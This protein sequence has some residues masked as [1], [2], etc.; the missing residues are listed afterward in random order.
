MK[1]VNFLLALLIFSVS[2]APLTHHDKEILEQ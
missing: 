2:A 1:I